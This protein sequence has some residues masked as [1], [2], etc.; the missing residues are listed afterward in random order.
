MGCED[1]ENN[2]IT[3]ILKLNKDY[4][5]KWLH[6]FSGFNDAEGNFQIY[7][8]K[9]LLLSGEI[10]KYNV[11]YGYHL[12]LH[13]R[14]AELL[15]EIKQILN[16]VGIF[17][18]YENKPDSRL[19]VND[20]TGLLYLIENVFDQYP[21]KIKNQYKTSRLECFSAQ[22]N[23]VKHLCTVGVD[24]VDWSSVPG[25]DHWIVG[26]INGEGSFSIKNGKCIFYLEHIDRQ[27]LEVIKGRL[28]FGPNVLE[29]PSR[30]R[31]ST[32]ERKITYQ[33]GVGSKK[34]IKNLILF[35]DNKDII[36]L[37]GHK[38]TQYNEWKKNWT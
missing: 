33:L 24:K 19:A 34:D 38:Y 28:D 26:F 10:S 37:Q 8:K 20:T 18:E 7:P 31:G 6:W 32:K 30:R 9:R 13:K 1:M 16:G 35:L 27:A 25:V 3:N 12:S 22:V 29:R 11:G 5:G 36:P 15:K 21:L 14:D 4:I 17:Y 2:Y 23:K